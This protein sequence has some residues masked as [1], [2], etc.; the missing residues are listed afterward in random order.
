MNSE[1]YKLAQ[2][3]VSLASD[4]SIS[5]AFAESCTG[6]LIGASVTDISGASCVFM[7]SAV[8][9]SN[10]AKINVLKVSEEIIE[11]NGAVSSECAIAMVCGAAEI[12]SADIAVSVT[13]VAG[14]DGGTE[15]KPVGTVWF[16]L[17]SHGRKKSFLHHFSGTRREIR[18]LTAAEA[19]KLII[20]ELS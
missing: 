9:Y 6:G 13:G 16:G 11:Q 3:T 14:P 5:I 7:G 8:T 10:N 15:E 19:L 4:K 20:E 2:K 1:L 12:Y 18:E 17:Y